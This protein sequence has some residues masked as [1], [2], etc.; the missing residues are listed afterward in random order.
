MEKITGFIPVVTDVKSFGGQ[1]NQK[2]T[3]QGMVQRIRRMSGFA[4]VLLRTGRRMAQCVHSPE[5]SRFPLDELRENMAVVQRRQAKG[6]RMDHKKYLLFDLRLFLS[7]CLL[8][9]RDLDFFTSVL[10]PHSS[11]HRCFNAFSRWKALS[12][13]HNSM[14]RIRR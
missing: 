9:G 11:L 13:R 10:H 1:I 6:N 14:K 3:L 5:W 2:I 4:F 8:R 7:R 12:M